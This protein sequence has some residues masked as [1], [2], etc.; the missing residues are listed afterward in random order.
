MDRRRG[1]CRTSIGADV[2]TGVGA[3]VRTGIRRACVEA[4]IGGPFGVVGVVVIP[5]VGLAV[6]L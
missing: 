6:E 1:H 3:H 4:S 5:E 2:G